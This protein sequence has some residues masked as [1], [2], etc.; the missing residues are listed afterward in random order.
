MINALKTT[1]LTK[2]QTPARN[3]NVIIK[4]PKISNVTLMVNVLVSSMLLGK[5]VISVQLVSLD[6]PIVN[7]VN[8]MEMVLWAKHVMQYLENVI[9]NR[10]LLGISV[11]N[12]P[13]IT[14]IFQR[15]NLVAVKEGAASI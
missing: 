1:I 11:Q 3:V 4:A 15:F 7:L 6:S 5:N 12:L 2:I 9:A 10:T 13:K 14:T 8:V